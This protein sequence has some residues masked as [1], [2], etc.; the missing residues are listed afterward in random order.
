MECLNPLCSKKGSKYK[1]QRGLIRHLY[2]N[3]S[4]T[5]Y[6]LESYN[7]E[8]MMNKQLITN[9]ANFIKQI[10]DGGRNQ[11]TKRICTEARYNSN[12]NTLNNTTN[13]IHNNNNNLQQNMELV[14]QNFEDD[15]SDIDDNNTIDVTYSIGSQSTLS[16]ND[17]YLNDNDCLQNEQ[18]LGNIYTRDQCCMIKLIKLLED[19]NCPDT[20]VTKIIDWAREA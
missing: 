16:S 19:M 4:C 1:S 6:Y 20:A 7:K 3:K 18:I 13:T 17:T 5:M 12:D 11:T 15:L 14:F 10:Q 2:S 8:T 9:N